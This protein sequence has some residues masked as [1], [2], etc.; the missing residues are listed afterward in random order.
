M[1]P[2]GQFSCGRVHIS[3]SQSSLRRRSLSQQP[4]ANGTLGGPLLGGP[5]LGGPSD[6][7]TDPSDYDD[8]LSENVSEP[9]DSP[10][11]DV[12]SVKTSSVDEDRRNLT[13]GQIPYWASPTLPTIREQKNTDQRIVGGDEAIPGEIPWQVRKKEPGQQFFGLFLTCF[14][15]SGDPDVPLGGPADGRAL[16]WRLSAQRLV[17]HHRR[18][19][20]DERKHR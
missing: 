1:F 4:E 13:E 17:G 15:P 11:I 20:P 12:R 19:L 5:L 3:S 14:C 18:P 7:V 9:L 16:L 6:T 10:G 8:Y 2:S